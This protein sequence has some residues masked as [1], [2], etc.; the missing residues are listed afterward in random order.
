MWVLW[1]QSAAMK[2]KGPLEVGLHLWVLWD[3]KGS[4]G[5]KL[6]WIV[7]TT[8][9]PRKGCRGHDSASQQRFAAGTGVSNGAREESRLLYS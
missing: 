9:L 8:C 1:D 7:W 4:L 6:M 3:L 5:K 2:A